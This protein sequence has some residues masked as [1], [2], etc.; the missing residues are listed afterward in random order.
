MHFRMLGRN[1]SKMNRMVVMVVA[2]WEKITSLFCLENVLRPGQFDASGMVK[3]PKFN[4]TPRV[5]YTALEYV[6][7]TSYGCSGSIAIKG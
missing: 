6:R 4:V 7:I 1:C 2:E 5:I 3:L